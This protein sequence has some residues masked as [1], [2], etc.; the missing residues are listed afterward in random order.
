MNSIRNFLI[1]IF[2]AVALIVCTKLVHAQETTNLQAMLQAIEQTPTV[3]ADSVPTFGTFW[4]AQHAPGTPQPWPPLPSDY[5]RVP[6]WN[7]GDGVYLMDDRQLDYA[8]IAASGSSMSLQTANLME[9]GFFSPTYSTTNGPY[10]TISPTGT[11]QY[12]ITVFNNVA[13]VSY[14]IW[15]TPVLANPAY[16][17]TV[18]AVGAT[19]QTNFT[20][21]ASV[22]PTGFYQAAWDTNGIPIWEEADPNNPSLGILSITIDSPTNG[23]TLH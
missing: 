2:F 10:L 18:L 4:S 1:R 15:W 12:V 9:E 22:Y 6:V 3:S 19:G 20:V 13:P 14:E 8:A 21:N 7:L 23:S 5:W 11:N 17:W 16:P